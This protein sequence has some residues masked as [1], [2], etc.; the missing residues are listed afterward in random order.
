MPDDTPKTYAPPKGARRAKPGRPAPRASADKPR[1]AD[2]TNA[3]LEA[4]VNSATREQ[5]LIMLIDGAI[6]F[7]LRGI[8]ALKAGKPGGEH[9][10]R[11]Q[12]IVAELMDS[13][14]PEIGRDLYE[15]LV[16]LYRFCIERLMRAAMQRDAAAAEEALR[17][18]NELRMLWTDA[19]ARMNVDGRPEELGHVPTNRI[20]GIG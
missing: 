12:K 20:D 14:K 3:Y 9:L 15:K 10:A 2:Q 17:V 1:H 19:I 8:D 18:L 13:L 6:G 5:L 16:G 7:A 11:A 4:A